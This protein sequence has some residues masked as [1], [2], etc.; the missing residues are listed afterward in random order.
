MADGRKNGEQEDTEIT[1]RDSDWPHE[2]SSGTGVRQSDA[3]VY[4]KTVKIRPGA[5]DR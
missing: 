3:M 1:E 5:F 2:G 4:C